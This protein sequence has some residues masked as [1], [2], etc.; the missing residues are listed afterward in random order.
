M[1]DTAL[2]RKDRRARIAKASKIYGIKGAESIDLHDA[3]RALN[4]NDVMQ[5]VQLAH[6]IT[7]SHP[8]SLHAWIIMGGAALAQREGTTA[9][10]FFD[11]ALELSPADSAALV[12]LSKA[13]VLQAK[14]EEATR[15]AARAFAAGATEKGLI[16]LYMDLMRHMGRIQVAID[17]VLPVVADLND[18]E[19]SFRL[20]DMLTEIEETSRAVEWLDR[21]WK[22]HPEEE[23]YRIGRL[24]SLIYSRRLDEA[25]AFADQLLED[26]EV[27]DNDTIVVYK[28][29]A[30]RILNR[31]LEALELADTHEFK[32]PERYAE[33]RGVVANI[34]QDI[35]RSQEAD[36]AYLEGL[37][38][39]GAKL[40]VSKAYGA[41]LMRRGDFGKGVEYFADR[42]ETR[43]RSFIPYENSDPE[44]LRNLDQ[45]FLIGEQ[46]VGDQL[47]LMSLL[48]LAPIDLTKT[49]VTLATDGRFVKG[50]VGNAFGL[51][52]LDRKVFT[53]ESRA[54]KPN[55]M[56]Y[57]GDMTRFVDPN[58]RQAHQGPWVTPDASRMQHLRDKYER[59]AKGG[60][61]I[62][63][64]WASGSMLGH[65]RSVTLMDILSCVPDGALVVNLQYGDRKS[66][67]EAARRARPD[68]YILD[69]PEVDQMADLA[70]FFA[71]VAAMDQ[72]LSIDNTTAHVCGAIGHPETHVLIPTG[73][74]CMWYWGETGDLDPWY[75]NL[76]LYRQSKLGVW[77]D[78][79]SLMK[80]SVC[81]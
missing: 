62:G 70:S 9:Q 67:I 7:I 39:T 42:F 2:S 57:I 69:D 4:Q 47:A 66:E 61:I 65:L 33:L 60:P 58:N 30:M 3:Y 51:D 74:E 25:V 81:P 29:L 52:V 23:Q 1:A 32:D 78:P 63:A 53:S 75:G 20:A 27:K 31:P 36:N 50:L 24:R 64:A 8:K 68:V 80:S 17:V 41:F 59:L 21:A 45:L 22:Q 73:S 49:K 28:V 19:L 76:N 11:R 54:L 35:G 26:P 56:M 71:Q 44:N 34:L 12:G 79:L 16:A 14:P 6:P 43:Q 18:P 48:R 13:Y 37:H 77:D 15:T 10:A 5:A 38:V 40:K 72:V 46:G 55:E